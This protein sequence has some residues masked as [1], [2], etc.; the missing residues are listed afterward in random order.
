MVTIGFFDGLWVHTAIC[1][2]IIKL[3]QDIKDRLEGFDDWGY[4]SPIVD[5]KAS[6]QI[7]YWAVYR[8]LLA[9]TEEYHGN[10][11]EI[12]K[13]TESG[14]FVFPAPALGTITPG[15]LQSSIDIA[16]ND[17]YTYWV[18]C[19]VEY[20]TNQH[21]YQKLNILT[22][23]YI[24]I[25]EKGGKYIASNDLIYCQTFNG[26]VYLWNGLSVAKLLYQDEHRSRMVMAP[27][28][29]KTHTDIVNYLHFKYPDAILVRA[30]SMLDKTITRPSWPFPTVAEKYFKEINY[31]KISKKEI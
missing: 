18:K 9:I 12:Q 29:I 30:N 1:D 11:K 8:V 26:W 24:R 4:L 22:C 6:S 20:A 5:M 13:L 7:I 16:V 2:G 19:I 10:I 15:N 14:K 17:F 3:P 25:I 23:P 27:S 31:E 28:F 21:K